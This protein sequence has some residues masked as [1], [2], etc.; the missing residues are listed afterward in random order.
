MKHVRSRQRPQRPPPSPAQA[1]HKK[2]SSANG[3]AW[4]A[5]PNELLADRFV[6]A[7]FARELPMICLSMNVFEILEQRLSQL[8]HP[9]TRGKISSGRVR[10]LPTERVVETPLRP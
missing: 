6:S 2:G 7:Q 10:T 9:D 5:K 1:C 8:K 4:Q 3:D